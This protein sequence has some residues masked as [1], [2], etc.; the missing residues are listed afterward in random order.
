MTDQVENQGGNDAADS[1]NTT[2]KSARM[3]TAMMTMGLLLAEAGLIGGGF[4]M[5]SE[6]TR[7]EASDMSIMTESVAI[8]PELAEV[9]I[10]DDNLFNET[11]GIG[12]MY[13][14]K[15]YLEVDQ[16]DKS[17]LE[18]EAQNAPGKIEAALMSIWKSASRRDLD[19]DELGA[20][21]A[22][23][24]RSLGNNGLFDRRPSSMPVAAA[25]DHGAPESGFQMMP[26][27]PIIHDVIVVMELGR[28]VNR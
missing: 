26:D 5:F 19:S 18:I 22:R 13:S 11:S 17:W 21:E 6:P 9:L 4:M 10:F 3:K 8:E 24:A 27:G 23:V 15:V 2:R 20:L 16:R 1:Q 14:T 7:T 25:P 28:R 12:F